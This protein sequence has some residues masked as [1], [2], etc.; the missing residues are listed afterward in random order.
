VEQQ[1]EELPVGQSQQ[2]RARQQEQQRWSSSYLLFLVHSSKP[3][4]AGQN[5]PV[6]IGQ[7]YP[8]RVQTCS[9]DTH[10]GIQKQTGSVGLVGSPKT[11]LTLHRVGWAKELTLCP[12]KAWHDGL[13][14]MMV[15]FALP[16]R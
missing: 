5:W 13:Q 12:A 11:Q 1:S 14:L 6:E 2:E 15:R 8:R 4:M 9:S 3:A 10:S 16:I 7:A